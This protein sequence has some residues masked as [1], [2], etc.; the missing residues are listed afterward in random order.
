MAK[1][2]FLFMEGEGASMRQ[3]GKTI[4]AFEAKGKYLPFAT[5]MLGKGESSRP[6]PKERRQYSIELWASTVF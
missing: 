2:F 4:T 6:H 1:S 5:D 3:W